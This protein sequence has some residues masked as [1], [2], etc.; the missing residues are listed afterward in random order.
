VSIGMTFQ[1][2]GRS[3]T[4][5]RYYAEAET[6]YQAIGDRSALAMILYLRGRVAATTG[7]PERAPALYRASLIGGR[8]SGNKRAL[9]FVLGAVAAFAATSGESERAV[10]L[11]S[12]AMAAGDAIGAVQPPAFQA[13]LDS[14]LSAA[15]QAVDQSVTTATQA[16]ARLMT[17]DQTVDEALAWLDGVQHR[18]AADVLGGVTPETHATGPDTDARVD[19]VNEMPAAH[20][21]A[22]SAGLTP[23]EL[24]VV[25][26][27]GRGLSNRQIADEMVITPGTAGNYVSR[28]MERLGFQSRAQVAAWAVEQGLARAPRRDADD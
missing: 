27:L 22:V 1:A 9:T 8:D 10:R 13:S 3:E 14:E 15:H 6:S 20:A 11:A 21:E 4:G 16:L 19:D 25:R 26:L 2:D 28:V 7:A 18:S 24:D 12:A 23:R 5:E 17:L